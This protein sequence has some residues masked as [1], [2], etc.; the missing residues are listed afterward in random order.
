MLKILLVIW[1]YDVIGEVLFIT[2]LK[3][4][5]CHDGCLVET[6]YDDYSM[7]GKVLKVLSDLKHGIL[8]V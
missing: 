8:A 7:I 4:L 5:M 3:K 1:L 2:R 6:L